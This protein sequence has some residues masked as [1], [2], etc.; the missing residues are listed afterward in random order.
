MLTTIT[1]KFKTG[2]K[3]K[4]IEKTILNQI[5]QRMI[6][7]LMNE[8]NLK[9][10][11]KEIK[12][13]KQKIFQ[14]SFST[15]KKTESKIIFSMHQELEAKLEEFRKKRNFDPE[16]FCDKKGEMLN[17]YMKKFGLKACVI[18]ISGGID[19]A[20]CFALC[21]HAKKLK[22]S[23][24]ERVLGITLP[25]HSTPSHIQ[26]AFD[27][28][29]AFDNE[30]VSVDQTEI[31]DKLSEI[32]EKAIGCEKP[33]KFARGQFRSYQRTP[34]NY[35]A[36]QILGSMGLPAIVIGTGNKDEDGYL[37]YFCKAGDGVVDVQLIADLHKN[38]VRQVAKQLGVI[39]S[40]ILAPPSADLWEG[41]TDE[42]EIGFSY[43]FVELITDFNDLSTEEQKDFRKSLGLEAR[44]QFDKVFE[45]AKEIH[46][47]NA[48]KVNFPVN[49]NLL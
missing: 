37:R 8:I 43:D 13:I 21:M 33:S 7:K 44:Q 18:A 34:I 27:L 36:T 28:G 39:E 6:S 20:V 31:H 3:R 25:I 9:K 32:V 4:I 19:S 49:L 40:I 42:D 22:D 17:E 5:N 2:I 1:Q 41:Q 11:I 16:T 47:K 15:K 24:I 46:R 45:K 26:R 35:F 12:E 38:E 30:V 48:H 29:K 23:P 10:E 14:N